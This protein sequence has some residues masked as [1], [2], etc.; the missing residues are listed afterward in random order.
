MSRW[1]SLGLLIL[2]QACVLQQPN[3]AGLRLPSHKTLACCW[4]SSEQ[5]V[6][7]HEG[8][9]L[10]LQSAML[11]TPEVMRLILFD[12]LGRRIASFEVQNVRLEVH[13]VAVLADT[14]PLDWLVPVV[15]LSHVALD[16]WPI[17]TTAWQI[18]RDSET[19]LLEYG[20]RQLAQV[21]HYADGRKPV[22]G[23]QRIIT[24][25]AQ[26]TVLT[27]TTLTSSML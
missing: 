10:Q 3:I 5:V 15:L 12:P 24:L 22:P 8:R 9:V 21:Q 2:L 18:R 23:E 27:V 14:L 7:K 13:K 11:V 26:K 17:Q 20:D 1:L 25:P 19:L 4:Q 16:E 6:I